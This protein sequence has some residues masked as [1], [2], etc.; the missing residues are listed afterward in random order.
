MRPW[1][2][3]GYHLSFTSPGPR[4]PTEP[5]RHTD[6]SYLV[7]GCIWKLRCLSAGNISLPTRRPEAAAAGTKRNGWDGAEENRHTDP[8]TSVGNDPGSPREKPSSENENGFSERSQATCSVNFR[9]ERPFLRSPD[10]QPDVP[11]TAAVS[12]SPSG[13]VA[14]PAVHAARLKE[15]WPRCESVQCTHHTPD[16]V[17]CQRHKQALLIDSQWPLT[18]YK[19]KAWPLERDPQP[20]TGSWSGSG[21]RTREAARQPRRHLGRSDAGGPTTF[22]LSRCPAHT[23][24]PLAPAQRWPPRRAA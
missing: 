23:A 15:R 2:L 7:T 16:P 22:L 5:P 20:L 18:G 17:R 24:L 1:K 13:K 21:R 9:T 14:Q 10:S 11:P 19:A 3:L 6:A 12:P 4:H 8:R